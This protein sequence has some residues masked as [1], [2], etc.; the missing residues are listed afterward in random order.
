MVTWGK[1]IEGTARELL[2]EVESDPNNQ[3]SA[4]KSAKEFLREVLADGAVPMKQ[5]E[6][7]VKKAGLACALFAGQPMILE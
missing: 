2:A 1:P 5:V 4:L 3:T 6:A 7:E